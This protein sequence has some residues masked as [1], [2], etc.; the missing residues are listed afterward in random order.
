LEPIFLSI[1]KTVEATG[2]SRSTVYELIRTGQLGSVKVGSRRLVPA[3]ELG[4]FA[5]RL[6]REQS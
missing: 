6:T 3:A 1:P 4:A 5:E 2:L